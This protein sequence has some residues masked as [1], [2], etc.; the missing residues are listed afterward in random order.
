MDYEPYGLIKKYISEAN[1]IHLKQTSMDKK[2]NGPF[3]EANNKNG[4][5]KALKSFRLY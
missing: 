4:L 5:I 3:T 1:Q 2:K